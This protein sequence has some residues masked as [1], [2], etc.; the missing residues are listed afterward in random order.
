MFVSYNIHS[1]SSVILSGLSL[2]S[3]KLKFWNEFE[4]YYIKETW[5]QDWLNHEIWNLTSPI[6]FLASKSPDVKLLCYGWNVWCH[7]INDTEYD[8]F[9]MFI[10][11]FSLML[12]DIQTYP[13]VVHSY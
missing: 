12:Y 4:K 2:M 7:M 1:V 3:K 11:C 8:F 10:K 9:V 5:I 13:V 6:Y